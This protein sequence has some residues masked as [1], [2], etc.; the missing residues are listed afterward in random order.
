MD[1][2]RPLISKSSSPFIN[3]LVTVPKVPIMLHSFFLLLILL[4]TFFQFY[5]VV[6]RDIKIHIFE[7]SIF[8]WL[9][10][11]LL[12]WARLG[13]PFVCQSPIGVYV[14]HSQRQML[15]WA[16]IIYSYNQISIPCTVDHISHIVVSTLISLL[17][18]FAAF[19]YYRIDSFVSVTT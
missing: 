8:C 10:Y 13:D 4:F 6:S 18:Q 7:S 17:C 12:F 16:Y 5:S 2:I 14:C 19:A 1:F 15:S 9:V 3:T 11:C